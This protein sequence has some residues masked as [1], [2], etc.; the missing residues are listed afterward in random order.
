MFGI[1]SVVI[2]L[3]IGWTLRA[4]WLVFLGGAEWLEDTWWGDL[5]LGAAFEMTPG[6]P[7]LA[8]KIIVGLLWALAVGAI[9]WSNL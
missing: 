4:T 6:T 7:C 3:F 1:D 2:A 8:V 9:L 5:L